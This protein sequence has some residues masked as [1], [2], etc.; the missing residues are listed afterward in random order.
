[1]LIRVLRPDGV[2]EAAVDAT[3]APADFGSDGSMDGLTRLDRRVTDPGD[4][5]SP[6]VD[7]EG[8]ILGF[9]VG[10]AI[11]EDDGDGTARSHTFVLTSRRALDVLN[12]P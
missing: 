5:G 2:V 9:V 1:M 6:V 11:V 4:S 7:R 3:D 10:G 8:N 12:S